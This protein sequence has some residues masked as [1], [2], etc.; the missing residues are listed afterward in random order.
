LQRHETTK[1]F[2]GTYLYKLCLRN[3]LA[4]SFREK[5]LPLARRDL[6]SLQ[7]L[8][9][10]GDPLQICNGI[11]IW[12]I[13]KEHFIEASKLYK[14]FS[15]NEEYKLRIEQG[16]IS[17]YSNNLPWINDI[18][19]DTSDENLIS[20]YQPNINDINKLKLN[21]ILVSQSN[22][23]E[24]KV[25]LGNNKGNESF[26]LWA[27]NNSKLIKIGPIL[28]DALLNN[29]YVSGMYFYARDDRTLQ[30]CTL[31]VSN[32]RRIDKLVVK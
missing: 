16:R 12:P 17:V 4:S 32:I 25:T 6:D 26:G 8:Y 10:V 2:Y 23:Y 20:L 21:V 18:I 13:S 3:Q 9:E 19:Y 29:G 14:H 5:N 31:M 11:R 24:Y 30:L 28:K 15:K 7:R 1:L 27:S 22:G